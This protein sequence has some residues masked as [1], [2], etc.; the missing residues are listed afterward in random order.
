MKNSSYYLLIMS[1]FV[2]RC[3]AEENRSPE[4]AH[5]YFTN[6]VVNQNNRE[7]A[8]EYK[9]ETTARATIVVDE[10]KWQ[11]YL[12]ERE[13]KIKELEERVKNLEEWKKLVAVVLAEL[14]EQPQH[15]ISVNGFRF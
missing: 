15:S 3:Y 8:V 12:Q 10:E 4:E 13:A 9:T 14:R 6:K 5:I 1:F 11:H 7:M 2:I